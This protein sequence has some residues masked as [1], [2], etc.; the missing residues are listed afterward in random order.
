[1]AQTNQKIEQEK[2]SI[3]RKRNQLEKEAKES[4]S[5]NKGFNSRSESLTRSNYAQENKDFIY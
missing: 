4:Y 3:L 2:E 5:R 1:M